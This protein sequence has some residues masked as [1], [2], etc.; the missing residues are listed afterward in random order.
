MRGLLIFVGGLVVLGLVYR[1]MYWVIDLE[2]AL[3]AG[4]ESAREVLRLQEELARLKATSA[5]ASAPGADL[6][7]S[8]GDS[9]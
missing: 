8:P 3:E 4:K 5:S 6:R 7:T 1:V 2:K 9:R